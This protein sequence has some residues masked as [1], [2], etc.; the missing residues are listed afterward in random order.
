MRR[1]FESCAKKAQKFGLTINHFA[2]LKN[3]LHLIVEVSGNAAL[4]RGMRSFAGRFARAVRKRMKIA[5]P[6][7]TGRYHLH[8]LKTPTEM[9]NALKYLFL[10]FARHSDLLD[11]VDEFCSAV[12]FH[13]LRGL[14][15]GAAN[16]LLARQLARWGPRGT[17]PYL[18]PPAS[19]LARAGWM[20]A[21]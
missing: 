6:V 8:V 14:L 16:P 12:F 21:G 5:G 4:G 10:N 19:W 17:P 2:I 15:K 20:R 9:K 7:F 11:H 3:H 1:E 13:D 18:R